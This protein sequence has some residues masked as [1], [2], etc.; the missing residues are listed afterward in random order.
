MHQ[1]TLRTLLRPADSVVSV[2]RA[3][4]LRDAFRQMRRHGY[5]QLPVVEDGRILG[6]VDESGVQPRYA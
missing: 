2:T 1:A 5:S 3:D 4:S 6:I